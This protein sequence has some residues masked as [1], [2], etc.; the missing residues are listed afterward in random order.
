MSWNSPNGP[1]LRGTRFKSIREVLRESLERSHKRA[2]ARHVREW[3]KQVEMRKIMA[4]RWQ[5]KTVAAKAAEEEAQAKADA[6][7]KAKAAKAKAKAD[8]KAAEVMAD[9]KA[10]TQEGR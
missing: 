3:G 10:E 2:F 5:E 7:A 4:A 9:A 8:A 1:L 6:K